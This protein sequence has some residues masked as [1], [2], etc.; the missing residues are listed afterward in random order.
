MYASASQTTNGSSANTS[1]INWT[2]T[3]AGGGSTYYDTGPTYLW[4]GGVERYYKAR[5]SWS[6][7]AF[8]AKAGS[9][10]G[11]FTLTHKEDGSIDP[12][13]IKLKSAIYTGEW[14][15][16]TV[17]KTWTLDKISR[18]FSSTPSVSLSSRTET[19]MVFNWS[20]SETCSEISWSGHKSG[21]TVTFTGLPGK[22]GTVTITG[23]DAN[24][25]YSMKGTFKRSDSGLTSNSSTNNYSTYNWPYVKSVGTATLKIGSQQTVYFYNPMG[26]TVDFYMKK[27][28]TS[29]TAL[30]TKTSL[31]PGKGENVAYSFTPDANT[32][33]NSIPTTTSGTA[34]YYCT[35]SSKT[36]NN[37]TGKYEIL[38][39]DAEKPTFT[40]S[41][42]TFQDA[43]T[44]VTNITG[45]AAGGW[46]VQGL[47]NLKITI[48]SK[49]TANKG[50]K[51]DTFTYE[52]TFAGMKKNLVV[53][54]GQEWGAFGGSGLQTI[55][56]KVI[57]ARGLSRTVTTDVNFIAYRAPS[58]SL[59]A[60]RANNYGETVN[61]SA[62]YTG[63]D[64]NGKNG[65][66][67]QWSGAG[68]SGYLTGSASAYDTAETGTKTTTATGVNNE[69]AYTFTATITDKF[70]KSATASI[71]VPVGQPTM[72]VDVEQAGVGVNCL[73]TGQGLYVQDNLQVNGKRLL[74]KF[75]MD[76][77]GLSADLFYPVIFDATNDRIDCEVYSPSYGGDHAWNQNS[78]SFS[79]KARGWSDIIKL[80]NIYQYGCHSG[81]EI[82]IGS[83]ANG[84]H[85]GGNTCIWLRGG[86]VFTFYSNTKATLHTSDFTNGDEVFSVGTGY[87]GG[88]TNAN[89]S[90]LFTPQSTI[91]EGAYFNRDLKIGGRMTAN[92]GLTVKGEAQLGDSSGA[93][94]L[95]LYGA[96]N[97]KNSGT[98]INYNDT[99][100]ST[101]MK[102]GSN[103]KRTNLMRIY[104]SDSA[105]TDVGGYG[106]TMAYT[107][108]GS[109]A[110]NKLVFLADNSNAASQVEAIGIS[111]NGQVNFGSSMTKQGANV[112]AIWVQSS[113]P[114]A[115]QTGDI[116]VV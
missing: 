83:I 114:T 81:S 46:L 43:A 60:G 100:G 104:S 30:F 6:S 109:G 32:L 7:F 102:I 16:T 108:D 82:T 61:I 64:V 84:Q 45:Q 94:N 1:T 78:I 49:A 11:S 15:S 54:T 52:V 87:A 67:V 71:N 75:D 73:P 51:A 29:G 96:V 63:S 66:K 3:T 41:Q 2:I 55:F 24:T 101:L 12:I 20:T 113:A 4:I 21:A 10:S 17:S 33:Y 95:N 53:G 50:A 58:I 28:N 106:Y 38:Q 25:T 9:T 103:N 48:N 44:A 79:I 68:K 112:P 88:S 37:P 5:T 13:E 65:V 107:G 19:S 47:S 69:T 110:G 18:Y 14:N 99:T 39:N 8:P 31:A 76:L 89:I 74:Q 35:Y 97:F 23:L 86:R 40:A 85:N 98:I 115:K 92:G 111:N 26:R 59:T 34:M 22:S 105:Y 27:D 91:V 72:F 93:C 56:V 62:T 57:D 90:T 116:W 42:I 80:F 77:S 36:V 70:G